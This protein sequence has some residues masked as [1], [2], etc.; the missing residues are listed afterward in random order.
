M[1]CHGACSDHLLT[2]AT[3]A[4]RELMRSMMAWARAEVTAVDPNVFTDVEEEEDEEKEVSVD[5]FGC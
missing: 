3:A 1:K 4:L 5:A 2:P